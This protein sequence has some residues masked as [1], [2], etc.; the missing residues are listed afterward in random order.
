[1]V[2]DLTLDADGLAQLGVASHDFNSPVGRFVN[3]VKG[4]SVNAALRISRYGLN[5]F[6]DQV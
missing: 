4:F 1:M 6:I 3:G 2:L 5:I